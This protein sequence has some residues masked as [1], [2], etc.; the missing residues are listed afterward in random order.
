MNTAVAEKSIPVSVSLVL[1]D[2]MR[3]TLDQGSTALTVVQGYEIT[4]PEDADAV[5]GEMNGYLR[6]IDKVAKMEEGYLKP[7]REL[8]E[9]HRGIYEPAKAGLK[10]AID[11]CKKLLSG[12]DERERKRIALENTQ[13][14]EAARKARQ[15]AEAIAARETARANQE[16]E[17]KR[18]KAQEEEAKGNAARAAQLRQQ[19]AAD[20]ENGAAR[21]T[22]AHLEA[23]ATAAAS[24]PVTAQKVAGTQMRDKWMAELAPGVADIAQAKRMVVAAITAGRTDLLGYLDLNETAIRKNAEGLHEAMSI[25]G[26]VAVNRPIVAGSKK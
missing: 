6:A 19:A 10:A 7:I 2:E 15:E 21:A 23:A 26:F 4:S 25:P 24:V 1:T 13:R 12:W 18:R 14:E 5:A 22:E 20:I 8:L 11:H 17:E 9:H 16:A 3:R